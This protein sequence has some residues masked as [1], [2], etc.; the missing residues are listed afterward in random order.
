MLEGRY[1]QH[2]FRK[3]KLNRYS[4]NRFIYDEWLTFTKEGLMITFYTYFRVLPPII[5]FSI[6]MGMVML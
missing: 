4:Y 2:L 3:N 1:W 6:Y 5:F